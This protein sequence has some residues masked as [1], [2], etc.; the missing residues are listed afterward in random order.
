[1]QYHLPSQNGGYGPVDMAG[2]PP[3]TPA[4]KQG[5]R[6]S[7]LRKEAGLSQGQ[8]A[9]AVGIP[10]RTLSFY[11]RKADHVPSDL[12]PKLANAL[13]VTIEDLLGL[14]SG[15]GSKR[16]PKS[17]LE[18]QFDAIRKL[19]RGRQQFVSQVLDE[20]IAGKSS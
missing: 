12:L 13:G 6:L 15:N 20:L 7:A 1:M 11:E 5:A 2:R 10:Q 8:L 18:R 19:P 9:D 3:L 17:R 4:T 16:G 14:R